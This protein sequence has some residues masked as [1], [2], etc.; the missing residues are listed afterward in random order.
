MKSC[1]AE[2]RNH[3]DSEVAVV[4]YV[5]IRHPVQHLTTSLLALVTLTDV[6]FDFSIHLVQVHCYLKKG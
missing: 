1:V 2:A 5:S 3:V 6:T 4:P